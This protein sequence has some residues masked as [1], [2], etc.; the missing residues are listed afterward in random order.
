MSGKKGKDDKP[1]Q[2]APKKE[3]AKPASFGNVDAAATTAEK[4]ASFGDVNAGAKTATDPEK[5]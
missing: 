2:E 5:H 1:A 4:P 3:A